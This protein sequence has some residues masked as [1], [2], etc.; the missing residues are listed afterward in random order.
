MEQSASSSD[1][2]LFPDPTTATNLADYV[3]L[4]DQLRVRCGE[5]S[6]RTLARKTG[7]LLRPPRVLAHT[8][9]ASVFQPRRRRLDQDLL[10]GIVRALT[11][12]ESLVDR[13]REAYLRIHRGGEAPGG[14]VGVFRQLPADLAIFI[15]REAAL[16]QLVE[17]AIR[18]ADEGRAAT[19]VV[20]AVEGMAGVGKTQLAIRAAHELL[21]MGHFTGLQL[22]V[23]L[24][25]FDPEAPPAD[26]SAVLEAFLRQ[27]GVAAQ[28]IP[29]AR[30]ERAAMF[31]DRLRE[32]SA[33]ILL[34]NAADED[35][36]RDLIPAGPDCLVLVTSRR[37]LAGLDG[38]TSHHLDTFTQA[39]SLQ[40]LSRIAGRDRVTAEPEA[41][42]RIIEY[43]DRLPLAVALTAARLRSRP[44]WSVT[45]MADHLQ[46]RRLNTIRAGG[47]AIRPVLDLSYQA[48][49]DRAR[50]MFR[51]LSV[52]PGPDLSAAAAA[53]L[54]GRAFAETAEILELLLDE[55]ML[56]QRRPARYELHDLLRAHA[57]ELAAR[58]DQAA[59]DM[60]TA[61]VTAWYTHSL[62]N[63]LTTLQK[64]AD[65]P[66]VTCEAEP[67]RFDS[68]DAALAWLA[69][70]ETNLEHVVEAASASGL[71]DTVWQA[72]RLLRRI[73]SE[74]GRLTDCARI[75]ARV[76]EAARKA[77]NLSAEGRALYDL[78]WVRT[79][80]ERL[81]PD[82]NL[83]EAAAC[84]RTAVDLCDRAGDKRGKSYALNGLARVLGYQDRHAE[85]LDCYEQALALSQEEGDLRRVGVT[86]AN[87]GTLHF[88]RKDYALALTSYLLALE[89]VDVPGADSFNISLFMGNI[90]EVYLLAG[91]YDK[92]HEYEARRLAIAQTYG[93]TM[94]EAESQL[95]TGDI[96]AAQGNR[97]AA[98]RAWTEA[99]TLFGQL[100]NPRAAEARQRLEADDTHD[101]SDA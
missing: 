2:R 1:N 77:G 22:Y 72:G 25:G 45:E 20:T 81:R 62:Y 39:E 34:D 27:L 98:R 89:M 40:L 99:A 17:S 93:Y 65:P 82:P 55:N 94:Q 21:R 16:R 97:T 15:G 90:A 91:E 48:L 53:A 12:D 78:G 7:P 37:S 101:A 43:C 79:D 46:A 18:S 31:R 32:H 29:A 60:A 54:S 23:N 51:L 30:D 26:P 64:N 5:P 4:L 13:W 11:A 56:Q 84:M 44:A 74:R 76:V 70:E 57:R 14:P 52:S 38:A 88:K 92:A 87:I 83:D 67:A 24:R 47:R 69:A 66:T 50:H 10:V 73:Y 6:Y 59:L 42:A 61:R 19:V 95:I 41:A 8:T 28:L 85:A 68:H 49:P 58:D 9:V 75:T 35:Q 100:G 86:H 63:A 80:L 71:H 96:Q 3:R 36:V 33:L